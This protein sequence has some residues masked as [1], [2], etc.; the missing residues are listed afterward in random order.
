MQS[1]SDLSLRRIHFRV[2]THASETEH[3]LAD[4]LPYKHVVQDTGPGKE[5]KF[6][7][8]HKEFTQDSGV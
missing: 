6:T 3:D 8:I 4:T 7:R 2:K 5:A 1:F